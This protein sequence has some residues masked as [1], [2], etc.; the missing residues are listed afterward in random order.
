MPPQ[1]TTIAS[2]A[3]RDA[4]AFRIKPSSALPKGVMREAARLNASMAIS[5]TEAARPGAA[6]TRN[7]LGLLGRYWLAFLERRRRQR[8]NTALH[9]LSDRELMDI[10]LTRAEIDYLTPQRAIDTLRDSTAYF[11]SRGVM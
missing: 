10:G 2:E 4:A 6:S 11:W 1:Q 7:V 8:L 9:Q 5:E 3:G